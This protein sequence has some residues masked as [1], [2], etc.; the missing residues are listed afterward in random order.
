MHIT[1]PGFSFL[2][3]VIKPA[4]TIFNGLVLVLFMAGCETTAPKN[5]LQW[6]ERTMQ[7]RQMQSRRFDTADEKKILRGCAL[8]LQDLGFNLTASESAVG[9]IN[10]Q[11]DRTAVE[12]DQVAAKVLAAIFL[13]AD[14]TIDARQ[15]MKASIVTR[16]QEGKIIVRV[17]FQ[18]VVYDEQGHVS[19]QE[20]LNEPGYYQEFF[21]RLSKSLFLTAHGI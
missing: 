15:K 20:P 17:T 5:A 9:L 19:R 14:V 1:H 21:E 2:T 7:N 16:P 3:Q 4:L 6:N 10:A 8:L 12:G 11:K 13:D 18:R